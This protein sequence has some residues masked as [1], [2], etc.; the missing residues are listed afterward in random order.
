M[1]S[2]TTPIE[3]AAEF[4]GEVANDM[5]DESQLSQEG[6]DAFNAIRDLLMAYDGYFKSNDFRKSPRIKMVE[7]R[8][9]AAFPEEKQ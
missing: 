3:R 6:V 2:E 4:L 7:E 8:L 1:A 5:F 9:A